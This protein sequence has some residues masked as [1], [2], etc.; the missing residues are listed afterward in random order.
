MVAG[1]A[2][3]TKAILE[4]VEYAKLL[5]GK[6]KQEAHVFL[7]RLFQAFGHKGHKEAGAELEAKVRNKD[8]KVN[9]A[10]LVWK[11]RCLIE[12][13]SKKAKL[14]EHYRQAFDYW[15]YCVPKRPRYVVLCNFDEF[16]IY[17]FD[18]QVHEPVDRVKLKD[19]PQRYTALNF[20]YPEA[21][22]P[23]FGN[24]RV[25][26]T[27]MAAKLVAR[28]FRS[29][30]VDR[31]EP[32]DS[33]Q[34]FVLQSVMSMFAEDIDLLP[35]GL[36]TELVTECADGKGSSYDLLGALFAQ[37]NDPKRAKAGRFAKVEH[38]NGGL[39]VQPARIELTR[40]EAQALALACNQNWA[41]VEPAIFGTLFTSS[42]D[43]DERHA[44]GA[45]FTGEA[46]IQRVVGP[47]IVRPFRER[48][49]Q[50]ANKSAEALLTLRGQLA[51]FRVLDPA[52]GSGNFLYVAY[53]ELRR[54]DAEILDILRNEYKTKIGFRLTRVSTKQF[55]GIDILEFAVELAKVTLMLAREL[56][57]VDERKL[58]TSTQALLPLE[59]EAALPLDNLDD[60]IKKADAL[61]TPWPEVDCII[62]NPPFQ[63]KNKMQQEIGAAKYRELRKH[64]PKVPGRANY[65]VYWFRKAHDHLQEGQR[66]GLV[67]TNTIRDNYSRE[68]GLDYI[69]NNG[70]TITEAVSSQVW[71]GEAVVHVS[72]VNWKKGAEPGMKRLFE[73]VGDQ[74]ESP[75]K[76]HEREVINSALSPR[77]DLTAAADIA[78]NE[79]P[80]VCYQGQTHG[81]EGFLVTPDKAAEFCKHDPKSGKY[82]HPYLI[83]ENLI[84]TTDRRPT[85]FV[86][87][88]QESNII[89][90]Q[91]RKGLFNHLK[92]SVLPHR[93]EEA[94]RERKRNEELKSMDPKAR[95]N[96]HHA[97]FLK[98]WWVLSYARV[99]LISQLEQMARYIAC[100]RHTKRPIFEFVS[101]K[102]RPGDS[103]QVF[104]L[105]DDY[106]FGILQSDLH[107]QWFV[108]RC[109]S[110][111]REWRYTPETVFASFPWPQ[112]PT[113][114]DV[115]RVAKAAVHVRKTRAQL[116]SKT[117]SSLRE[118]Y[119]SLE[120]PG[121][122]PLR[123]VNLELDEAVRQAY[124][125]R[126][127]DDPLTRL[128]GLNR[129][130]SA[131]E[132]RG[133]TITKPGFPAGRAA[134]PAKFITSDCVE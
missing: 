36:F 121:T 131:R 42:M 37:M 75:W 63:S 117:G 134:C 127:K 14:N 100:V 15:I 94:E 133:E 32:R 3:R 1:S 12:M 125:F 96:R 31:K 59:M 49:K 98:T 129:E 28:V 123:E 55:Y 126:E 107:W 39:F 104:T 18:R 52:C 118:L 68:G 41:A 69:V 130:V 24:D 38:F 13:K 87:D 48:I 102:I 119:R 7:E 54:L 40:D 105:E 124:G 51:G 101:S 72:I 5:A 20:L 30:V 78:G 103:L 114:S 56:A 73:Q 81:H 62:G 115:E 97:N 77:I 4:F 128:L 82:L 132:K 60:N 45:H 71:P 17:D 93:L 57:I 46:E 58:H 2:D 11:P 61:L 122:N 33:A 27:E 79:N 83:G 95:G 66:A 43:S 91:A 25:A 29:L 84:G 19:L 111:K 110:I 92:Q 64:Y 65:C 80:K 86:I 88:F 76:V 90:A 35:R 47:T 22:K 9:F 89:E 6:E 21:P 34:R 44:K 23:Q 85:R 116:M 106:S 53:R 120:V 67:G 109:S 74:P 8:S 108:E 112:D 113:S 16:W 50:A 10:D 99:D 26:V 70:G